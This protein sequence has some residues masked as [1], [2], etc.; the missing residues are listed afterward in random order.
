MYISICGVQ[1]KYLCICSVNYVIEINLR[2]TGMPILLKLILEDKDV[3]KLVSS[4]DVQVLCDKLTINVKNLIYFDN[5]M[6]M[7]GLPAMSVQSI[8][9]LKCPELLAFTTIKEATFRRMKNRL[10]IRLDSCYLG[11]LYYNI[12]VKICLPH[13]HHFQGLQLEQF[14]KAMLLHR[15]PGNLLRLFECYHPYLN[16]KGIIDKLQIFLLLVLLLE[17]N[18]MICLTKTEGFIPTSFSSCHDV[19]NCISNISFKQ[20]AKLV[21]SVHV[22]GLQMDQTLQIRETL[23]ISFLD[24][25]ILEELDT[26]EMI[27]LVSLLKPNR[28]DT[29]SLSITTPV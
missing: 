5:M 16:C 10:D 20:A 2:K 9:Q 11:M 25:I 12:Y 24:E 18:K 4:P 23:D 21:Y 13:F 8:C 29:M 22:F 14:L 6:A 15:S 1:D 19:L 27:Q 7:C 3:C 26:K 28:L 17:K